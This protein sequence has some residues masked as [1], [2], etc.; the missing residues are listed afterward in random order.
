MSLMSVA[1]AGC[2]S[3][4]TEEASAPAK[5]EVKGESQTSIEEA[6]PS[7]V[8]VQGKNSTGEY[9]DIEVP[10][11]P[12]KIVCV[13]YVA[14]DMIDSWGL[15]DRIVGMSKDS[16][17]SLL[18]EYVENTEIIN[19]GGLKE[20]D[21]E[22]IMELEPDLIFTSGRMGSKYDDFSMI[23]PTLMTNTDYDM[24]YMES[25]E[26]HAK[27]N[28]QPFGV[29]DKV[30]EQ[31]SGYHDRIAKIQEA[32]EGK[33]V[34][35]GLTLG[36]NL[37]TLGDGS[38]GSIVGRVLGFDNIADGIDSNHG[39]ASSYELIL[40]L[41]PDYM[42]VIDKDIATNVGGA[43]AAPQLLDNEIMHQTKAWQNGNIGFLA[44]SEWYVGEGGIQ[45][46]DVMLSDIEKVLFKAE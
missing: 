14:V 45:A 31:L 33:T 35:M 19:L 17:P 5:T 8:I 9:V 43:V 26:F 27:R 42:F 7:T 20:V 30:A 46:M 10:Y 34:V 16:A 11:D 4:E 6:T 29:E 32:A 38:K 36:G 12:Q 25:F 2:S 44:P 21:M 40:D 1:M 23:A 13:D 15:G 24:E 41:N 28:A 3:S 18:S 39:N 22:A 37:T